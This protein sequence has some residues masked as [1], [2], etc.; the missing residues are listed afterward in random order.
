MNQLM[1]FLPA[2]LVFAAAAFGT[3]ALVLL[4]EAARSAMRRRSVLKRLDPTTQTGDESTPELFRVDN[5][6]AGRLPALLAGLGMPDAALRLRQAGLS[7]SPQTL[8]LLMLGLGTASGGTVWLATGSILLGAL[9][10]ACAASL[11]NL[12][13]RH[14]K[15]KRLRAFEEQF[16]EAIEMLGRAIRAGHPLSAGIRM[17]AD[18]TRDPISSEFNQVFEENRFG[19]PF[20]DALMGLVDRND[21]VDARIFVT[22][23]L[24]QREVGGN[25]AEI[26]DKIAATV[27]SRFAV[28]RQLRVYTAQGRLSGYVLGALP[29]ILTVVVFSIDPKY[30]S[31][32]WL[33][34]VGRIMVGVA[35]T[36]QVLGYLWIRKIVAI[37]I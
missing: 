6:K 25:L 20:D 4:L 15:K 13:V 21:L 17:V 30:A 32:L 35:A 10:G 28:Q 5:R 27:R 12:Y 18:E 23:V 34:P 9:A 33:E 11:P 24:V 19:L 3:L 26:L 31:M 29:I 22:A 7:W 1:G 16:P 14:R 8:L 2:I 37:E 36:M